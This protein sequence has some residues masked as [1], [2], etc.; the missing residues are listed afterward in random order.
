MTNAIACGLCQTY[1]S[2]DGGK[3]RIPCRCPKKVDPLKELEEWAKE[4]MKEWEWIR[5]YSSE[6][7]ENNVWARAK[8]SSYRALLAKIAELRKTP[9]SK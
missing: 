4:H 7:D 8:A 6:H 1:V 3:T 2:V 5:D 9:S